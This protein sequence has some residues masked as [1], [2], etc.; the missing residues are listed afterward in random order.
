MPLAAFGQHHAHCS[1]DSKEQVP[2][3]R[4]VLS[5]GSR[6]TF[7]EQARSEFSSPKFGVS[8]LMSSWLQLTSLKLCKPEQ[9]WCSQRLCK[10]CPWC[11][12]SSMGSAQMQ[13]GATEGVVLEKAKSLLSGNSHSTCKIIRLLP[14][15]SSAPHICRRDPLPEFS[16]LSL[17]PGKQ[18]DCPKWTGVKTKPGSWTER[19]K[20]SRLICKSA[21][22]GIDGYGSVCCGK[23][24]RSSSAE[25]FRRLLQHMP[26]SGLWKGKIVDMS[27]H[28]LGGTVWW[29]ADG[30]RK[31]QL[32]LFLFQSIS[33]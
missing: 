18:W 17:L 14:R 25:I 26:T 19:G 33:I 23:P 6:F 9:S 30:L 2:Q 3:L 20:D 7:K 10:P 1:Y 22:C 12:C 28:G 27:G 21:S 8:C 15:S 31:Y 16:S 32:G 29:S 13:T 4:K 11:S 5:K 24:Q